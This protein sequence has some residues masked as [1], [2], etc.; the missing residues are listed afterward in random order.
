MEGSDLSQHR[1]SRWGLSVLLIAPVLPIMQAVLLAPALPAITGDFLQI[2]EARFMARLLLV[3]P[4]V[5]IILVAPW[6]GY[7]A[8]RFEKRRLLAWGFLGYAACGIIAFFCTTLEQIIVTRLVM[9]ICLAIVVTIAAVLVGDYFAGPERETV[10][11]RQN[12]GRG[13]VGALFPVVGGLIVLFDWRWIFLANALA[14]ALV[15][16]SW[17]LPPSPAV[18]QA[19]GGGPF[20][21]RDA[22]AVYALCFLGALVLYLLTLQ[23]AFHLAEMGFLSAV[24]PGVALGLAS[25]SAAVCSLRYGGVRP[26]L[27]FTSVA[28]LAFA[29]MGSGYALIA[30]AN[31]TVTVFV[32]LV[33]A[34][35]GFGLNTPNC[36]AWLLAKV[37]ADVRAK[38]LGGLTTAFF[39]GQLVSPFVYEPIVRAVGSSGTFALI[40]VVS[41]LVAVSVVMPTRRTFPRRPVDLH[42]INAEEKVRVLPR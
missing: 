5:A 2:P 19:G 14:L 11:G 37:G 25:L 20:R 18:R 17:M 28:G 1:P 16:P 33:L 22:L 38:A 23:I 32:G 3:A 6:I 15:A 24:W 10:L 13:F 26:R 29:L 9:G 21:H 31:S 12:A 30:Y 27:S 7:F 34:G 39:L 35:L 41:F 42:T 36:P 40:S 8:E 4:T